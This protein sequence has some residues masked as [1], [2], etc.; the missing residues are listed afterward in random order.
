MTA[1]DKLSLITES[2]TVTR[3]DIHPAGKNLTN[4]P[5]AWLSEALT[6]D[7]HSQVPTKSKLG[8]CSRDEVLPSASFSLQK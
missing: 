4:M 3:I 2:V 8:T 1:M 7:N 6:Y 5:Y